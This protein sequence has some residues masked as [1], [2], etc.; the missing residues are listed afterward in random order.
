MMKIS[1]DSVL[2]LCPQLFGADFTK[3]RI[4]LLV[5]ELTSILDEIKKLRELDIVNIAPVVIFDA[6]ATY[7]GD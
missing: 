2:D 5:N 7:K 4:E 1:P 6:E 3:E